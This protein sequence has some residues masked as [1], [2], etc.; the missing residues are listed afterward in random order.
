MLQR[1]VRAQ[2]RAG[3]FEERKEAGVAG[4]RQMGH[5]GEDVMSNAGPGGGVTCKFP[6]VC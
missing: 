3:M 4:A 5:V 1:D 2:Q 6:G